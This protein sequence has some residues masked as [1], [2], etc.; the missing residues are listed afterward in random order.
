M[1]NQVGREMGRDLYWSTRQSLTSASARK[2]RS[3]ARMSQIENNSVNQ[4]LLLLVSKKKWS[5]RLRF[6]PMVED[7]QETIDLVDEQIDTSSFDWKDIYAELDN[8]IDDLK[9]TCK[10]E[11]AAALEELDQ[12]NYVSFSIAKSRHKNWIKQVLASSPAPEKAPSSL[13]IFALSIAGLTSSS[14]KRGSLNIVAEILC[15]FV[16]WTFIV[17]GYNYI[18]EESEFRNGLIL[19]GIGLGF[20]SLVLIGNFI[21]LSDLRKAVQNKIQRRQQLQAYYDSL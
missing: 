13:M 14:L 16:W 17:F 19:M 21:A 18:Q 5:A 8:K 7:I 15:A 3:G 10:E 20:Y 1:I 11:E 9:L 4:N 6:S 2:G 12:K